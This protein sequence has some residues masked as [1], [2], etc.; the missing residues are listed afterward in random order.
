MN[1]LNVQYNTQ[2]YPRLCALY[3]NVH[4]VKISFLSMLDKP[5]SNAENWDTYCSNIVFQLHHTWC[6]SYDVQPKLINTFDLQFSGRPT[7]PPPPLGTWFINPKLRS[8]IQVNIFSQFLGQSNFKSC[9]GDVNRLLE[10]SLWKK[11][12]NMKCLC[13]HDLQSHDFL[14]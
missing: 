4:R 8:L 1:C 2:L 10:T 13:L 14:P 12:A 5:L 7:T 11:S 6:T 9:L 3:D